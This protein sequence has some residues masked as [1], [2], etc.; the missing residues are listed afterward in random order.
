[1]KLSASS[2]SGNSSPT[3]GE[4]LW[5]TLP[6]IRRLRILRNMSLASL[7]MLTS[8]CSLNLT[9]MNAK[10]QASFLSDWGTL[11]LTFSWK[12]WKKRKWEMPW[13]S[14]QDRSRP[15]TYSLEDSTLEDT[16]SWKRWTTKENWKQWLQKTESSISRE[17]LTCRSHTEGFTTGD[18]A[19]SG[20]CFQLY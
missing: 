1:M 2:W 10:W 16:K 7:R 4:C 19:H 18:E 6:W 5:L 9:V 3:S 11:T 12:I 17:S 14:T 13:D 8:L 20:F 15:H